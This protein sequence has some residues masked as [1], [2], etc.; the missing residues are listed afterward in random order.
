M[1]LE[2][3]GHRDAVR[4]HTLKAGKVVFNNRSSVI[5]CHIVDLTAKGACIELPTILGI[6]PEFELYV[7]M[8]KEW[9]VCSV[10]WHSG[11]RIGVEFV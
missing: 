2:V 4:H 7:E 11:C 10:A 8:A 3:E 1:I 6:P 9:H 5:T